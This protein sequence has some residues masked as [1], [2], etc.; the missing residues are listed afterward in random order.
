MKVHKNYKVKLYPN[1]GQEEELFKILAGCRFVWNHFLELRKNHYLEHKKTLP[2]AEMSRMLTKLRKTAPELDGIQLM[3]LA[4]ELRRLDKAY[5]SFFRK[6]NR[7]PKFKSDSMTGSFCRAKDWGIVGNK[8]KLQN[9]LLLKCRGTLPAGE[10]GGIVVKYYAGDWYATISTKLETD[11]P[12]A[13]G[14]PIGIDVGIK[15]LATLSDGTKYDSVPY[16]NVKVGKIHRKLNR[17][18]PTSNR[19]RK[20]K[21][22]LK[23]AYMEQTNKRTDRLHKVSASIV[24]GSPSLVA[25]EDLNVKGMLKNYRLARVI[26]HAAWS[27]FAKLITYKTEWKGGK[28]VKIDR[29][30]PSSKT[31]S[32]CWYVLEELPLSEREW[33]CPNCNAHHDRDINAAKVILKQGQKPTKR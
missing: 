15:T 17:R 5:N 32:E 23:R 19:Y 25:I 16:D 6:Q 2:Y 29:F 9:N 31:C 21:L 27:Q 12:I 11:S 28:V 7:F 1:K 4:Q 18:T 24:S 20:T 30:Y 22:R 33:D 26:S 14:S 10:V 8:V 13:S 3:P